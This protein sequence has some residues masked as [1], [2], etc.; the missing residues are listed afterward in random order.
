MGKVRESARMEDCTFRI[1]D[2][3]NYNPETT[4]YCHTNRLQD[5]K[6]MGVKSKKGA[7]GCS[8]CHDVVDGRAPRPEGMTQD[9]LE[10][11]VD[12]AVAETDARLLAKG[13]PTEDDHKKAAMR[14]AQKLAK[15]GHT[16]K[17]KRRLVNEWAKNMKAMIKAGKK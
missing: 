12:R 17:G 6:G 13:L 7:Y 2:V 5:G 10:L 11:I 16:K 1:P 3:C 15:G 4:V 9:D 14:V 8:S